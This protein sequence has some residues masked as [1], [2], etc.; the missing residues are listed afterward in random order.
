MNLYRIEVVSVQVS[1]VE[2]EV[3][4]N[5]DIALERLEAIRPIFDSDVADRFHKVELLVGRNG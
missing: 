4:L 5:I 3:E 1:T 2:L